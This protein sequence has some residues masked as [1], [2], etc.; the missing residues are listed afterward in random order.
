MRLKSSP[1]QKRPSTS[2]VVTPDNKQDEFTAETND[3]EQTKMEDNTDYDVDLD[4]QRLIFEN[5]MVEHEEIVRTPLKHR[6]KKKSLSKKRSES[7]EEKSSKKSK[8]K[9]KVIKFSLSKPPSPETVQVIRVDVTSNYSI[10]LDNSENESNGKKPVE[11]GGTRQQRTGVGEIVMKE[12]DK[13]IILKCQRLS[14][15]DRK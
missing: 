13:D 7:V 3:E 6:H 2:P 12:K 15:T 1:L 9:T 8:K 10:E 11:Y 5:S 14:L 4:V